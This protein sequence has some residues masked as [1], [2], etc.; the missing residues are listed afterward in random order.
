MS[1]ACESCDSLECSLFL[2]NAQ[3]VFGIKLMNTKHTQRVK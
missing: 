2:F 3:N 1:Y